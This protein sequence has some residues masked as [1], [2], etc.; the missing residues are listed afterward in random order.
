[1]SKQNQ[2]NDNDDNLKSPRIVLFEDDDSL[3][4][5]VSVATISQKVHDNIKIW[6]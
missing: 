4:T 2:H 6:V 3:E 1:M 5:E